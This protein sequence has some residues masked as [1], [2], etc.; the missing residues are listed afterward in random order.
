MTLIEKIKEF[1]KMGYITKNKPIEEQ[2][3]IK[4]SLPDRDGE[5]IIIVDNSNGLVTKSYHICG[6]ILKVSFTKRELEILKS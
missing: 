4:L 6:D 5:T 2:S 3:M 1:E